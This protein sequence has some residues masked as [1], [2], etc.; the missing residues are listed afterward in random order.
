MK[1]SNAKWFLILIGVV[2]IASAALGMVY[3]QETD[4][5]SLIDQDLAQAQL[6]LSRY[7]GNLQAEKQAL[8]E[9]MT[10]ARN[11][12]DALKPILSPPIESIEA[13]DNLFRV[14][15]DCNM[16]ILN[17]TASVPGKDKLN[18]ANYATIQLGVKVQGNQT[19]IL[20]FITEWTKTYPTGVI[21]SVETAL[22]PTNQGASDNT[23]DESGDDTADGSSDNTNGA[24]ATTGEIEQLILSGAADYI[25]SLKLTI[26]TYR[27]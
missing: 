5:Q 17:V 10:R 21:Q 14:A 26:Y 4:K 24:P 25:S 9:N 19:G 2:V 23:T 27:G 3:S 13:I 15:Q 12:I 8:T 16:Q 20:S 18:G 7:A 1:L 6:I 11:E 22:S